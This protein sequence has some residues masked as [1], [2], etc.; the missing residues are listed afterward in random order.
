MAELRGTQQAFGQPGFP[1]RWSPGDKDG[2]GTAYSAGSRLWYTLWKGSIS[3]VYYPTVDRPQ[4]RDLRL[5][6]SDG[7]SFCRDETNLDISVEHLRDTLGYEVRGRD[8]DGGYSFEKEIISDPHA[9]C[10]LQRIK[11]SGDAAILENL[12]VY[13]LCSP[14]IGGGQGN[15]G[16]VLR[17]YERDVLVAHHG[18]VWLAVA[19]TVPFAKASAGYVGVSDGW[20]DLAAHLKLDWQFDQAVEGNIALIGELD[21]SKTREFTLVVAFGESRHSA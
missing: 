4:T 5:L 9:P 15:T 12:K 17:V 18:D 14:N 7:K 21:L 8:L 3:E 13:A 2:I 20:T 16:E 6:F 11:L 1:P 19:A 10:V